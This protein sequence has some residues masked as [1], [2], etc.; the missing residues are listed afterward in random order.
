MIYNHISTKAED[1]VAIYLSSA[2]SG[3]LAGFMSESFNHI[4][5]P[6]ETTASFNNKRLYVILRK[7]LILY[8]GQSI[9]LQALPS[10]LGFLAYEFGI[11]N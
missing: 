11:R 10:G 2:S 8:R 6:L 9:L 1:E 4:L 5:S 3:L 7:Q